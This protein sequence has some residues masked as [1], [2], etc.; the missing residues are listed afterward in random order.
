MSLS[1]RLIQHLLP[2]TKTWSL[3]YGSTIRKYCQGLA[4]GLVDPAREFIDG[5]WD[6]MWPAT[7]D[8]LAEWEQELGCLGA[9][10][11]AQRRLSLAA[12]LRAT[13]GQSGYYIQS[14]VQAAGF[15]VYFHGWWDPV[16]A[17]VR[18]PNNY[19]ETAHSGTDQC[20]GTIDTIQD[21]CADVDT[22]T[23]PRCDFFLAN[24]VHYVV[25][26]SL[27]R[28]APPPLPTDTSL[29]R[30]FIYWCGEEFGTYAV[31]DADRILELRRLLLK[32]CP[33]ES[34]LIILVTS[35]TGSIVSPDA[36]VLFPVGMPISISVSATDGTFDLCLGG[37]VRGTVTVSGGAGIGT[38]TAVI[39]D[40][41]AS[42]DLTLQDGDAIMDTITI[43]VEPIDAWWPTDSTDGVV[44]TVEASVSGDF[45]TGWSVS[46]TSNGADS[47]KCLAS[48]ARHYTQETSPSNDVAGSYHDITLECTAAGA[49]QWIRLQFDSLGGTGGWVNFDIINGVVGNTSDANCTGTISIVGGVATMR[50][51]SRNI[52]TSPARALVELLNQ[53]HAATPPNYL[54]DVNDGIENAALEFVQ[55]R[56][57][58]TDD[59]SGNGA[60]LTQATDENQMLAWDETIGSEV[61]AHRESGRVAAD[62][63]TES[64]VIAVA[65]GD[66]PDFSVLSIWGGTGDYAEICNWTG[67]GSIR[68][69]PLYVEGTELKSVR[70]DGS[71]EDVQTYGS[72]LASDV[73]SGAAVAIIGLGSR[74]RALYVDGVYKAT[75]THSDLNSATMTSFQRG[76]ASATTPDTVIGSLALRAGTGT[77]AFLAA[78]LESEAA[79]YGL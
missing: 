77:Y 30:K 28:L 38:C 58:Q 41:G 5:V 71:T 35:S 10:T 45:S 16:G 34:W 3:P 11:V 48:T 61:V 4:D 7:T 23:P 32:L 27:S 9:G 39:G 44:T 78:A 13:G 49:Q 68:D 33:G 43:A 25:N 56:I 72:G 42:V 52:C 50:A 53:D 21:Q 8:E 40:V 36:G 55:V 12:E 67:A 64:G 70:H 74:Q 76:H 22:D 24:D 46:G 57:S 17:A 20:H 63:T 37:S 19:T 75:V 69:C 26:E 65:S 60:D 66:D 62:A 73:A 29:Y 15:D 59:L 51:V 2:R 79:K 14:I 1:L 54:G 18:D 31:V 6:Q 47:V